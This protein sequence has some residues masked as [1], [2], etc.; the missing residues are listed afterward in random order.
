MMHLRLL[1]RRRTYL[2]VRALPFLV[3]LSL[4]VSVVWLVLG[5]LGWLG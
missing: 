2:T 5:W 3:L 4:C 1:A